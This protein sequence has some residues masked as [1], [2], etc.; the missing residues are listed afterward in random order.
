MRVEGGAERAGGGE[1]PA[2]RFSDALARAGRR[3]APA[4]DP[5]RAGSRPRIAEPR[6][7]AS[8]E[9]SVAREE[10]RDARLMDAERS[11]LA[12]EAPA[13]PELAAAVRTLPFAIA[14]AT[15]AG[16]GPLALSFGRS[17]DVE[18]RPGVAGVE[19]VLRP[20]PRLLRAAEAELPRLVEAL[21]LRGVAV[22]SAAVRPRGGGGRAR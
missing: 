18:L 19:V 3:N 16:G 20:E 1:S 15:A 8:R 7:P 2:S 21:R 9:A 14:C 10:S 4:A 5:G 12:C 17:L 22:A 6:R 13:I 11:A